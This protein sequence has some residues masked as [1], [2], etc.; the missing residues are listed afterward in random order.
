MKKPLH[1]PQ[2]YC[3]THTFKNSLFPK[4]I[5]KSNKLD[6][7]IKGAKSFSLF[8]ASLL[9]KSRPHPKSTYKIYNP[10]GIIRFL[11]RLGLSHLN[12]YKCRYFSDCVK[13]IYSCSI[14]PE[15]TFHFFLHCHNLKLLDEEPFCN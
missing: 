9:K 7:K 3:K 13:P 15:T 6:E 2:Y 11:T 4:V 5:N 8:K 14:E 12:K 1:I 10:I